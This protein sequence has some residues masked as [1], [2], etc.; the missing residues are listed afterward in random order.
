MSTP[1]SEQFVNVYDGRATSILIYFQPLL[2]SSQ[3][4]SSTDAKFS[5]PVSRFTQTILVLLNTNEVKH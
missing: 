2:S 5:K 1:T 4:N 3:Y